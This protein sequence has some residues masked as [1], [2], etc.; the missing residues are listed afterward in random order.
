MKKIKKA[1][2]KEKFTERQQD[3]YVAIAG[4]ILDFGYSPTYNEVAEKTGMSSQS[5]EAHTKNLIKKGWIRFNGKK[6][7]KL[8]LIPKD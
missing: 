6:F 5:V 4:Y 3:V 7:R 8:E 2:E 1:E